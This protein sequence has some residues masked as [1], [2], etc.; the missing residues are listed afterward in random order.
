MS[1]LALDT[2]VAIP[3]LMRSHEAHEAVRQQLGRRRLTLATHS[4][5][6]TYA[7]LTRLPGDARVAP[8]D[9][10]TLLESAFD[11]PLALGTGTAARL[12]GILAPLGVSGGAVYDT[13]VGLAALEASVPLATRDLRRRP[14]RRR[15]RRGLVPPRDRSDPIGPCHQG[16]ERSE[17]RVRCLA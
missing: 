16:Q 5:A 1:D 3:Y 4:L 14:S 12:P 11:A 8:A 13:L 7:V 10:V 6:E 17:G 9:A 2:S 15:A